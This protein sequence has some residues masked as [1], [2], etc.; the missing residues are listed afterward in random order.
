M[1][2]SPRRLEKLRWVLT[3]STRSFGDLPITDVFDR[4]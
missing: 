3:K 4:D 2:P 1:T